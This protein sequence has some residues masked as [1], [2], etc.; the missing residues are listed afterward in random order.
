MNLK[1]DAPRVNRKKTKLLI[2]KCVIIY[3]F[4]ISFLSNV[5]Q[6][7]ISSDTKWQENSLFCF[8]DALMLKYNLE[9]CRFGDS[10]AY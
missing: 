8:Y 5:K 4:F 7:S 1:N 2:K 9:V 3:I 6:R 10:T